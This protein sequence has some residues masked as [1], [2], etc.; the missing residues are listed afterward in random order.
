MSAQR[1]V[2]VVEDDEALRSSLCA[3]LEAA[4]YRPL[5]CDHPVAPL[6][7]Q[8]VGPALIVTDL[9]LRG[10][11]DGYGWLEA[12]RAWPWTAKLPVLV[13]SGFLAPDAP[14]AHRVRALASATL[15]KPFA[16]DA[17]LA[18]VAQC[19]G[20]GENATAAEHR[21]EDESRNVCRSS[22]PVP[23]K[24]P[25]PSHGLETGGSRSSWP[26]TAGS[27]PC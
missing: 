20:E 11:P 15:R 16:L 8:Q 6:D 13:C 21:A 14:A 17:F 4:G 10:E 23:E 5:P 7:V 25:S 2:L 27:W 26:T 12:L 19:L 24:R 22:R 18:T 1:R 9:M 3:A